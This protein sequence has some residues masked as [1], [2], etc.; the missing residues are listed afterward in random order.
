[1]TQTLLYIFFF[2]VLLLPTQYQNIRGILLLLLCIS[3][4]PKKNYPINKGII[5]C[6]FL[7]VF[8]TL[9]GITYGKIKGNPGA[10]S[11]ITVDLLWPS[12]YIFFMLKC[13]SLD[14]IYKLIKVLIYGG[15]FV[16]IFNLIL[17]TNHFWGIEIIHKLSN[18][19]GY[20]FGFYDGFVE[21]FTPSLDFFSYFLFFSITSLLT[22]SKRL[23]VKNIYLIIMAILSIVMILLSGRRMMWLTTLSLPFILFYIFKR[24]NIGSDL[25]HKMIKVSIIFTFIIGI[26]LIYILDFDSILDQFITS[27]EFYDDPSNL[28]RTLQAQ[29]LWNDFIKSP[30]IGQGIGWASSYVRSE[31]PWEYELSYNYMLASLGLLGSAVRFFSTLWVIEKCLSFVKKTNKYKELLLPPISGLLSMLINYASNPYLSKFDFLWIL[32]FPIIILN[33]LLKTNKNNIDFR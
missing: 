23:G 1:M 14:V 27:F 12:L 9:L 25:L 22:P 7:N 8:I 19:L 3:A 28:E 30:I 11:T 2:F 26:F 29:S 33:I 5:L 24:A 18:D 31:K 4:I 6:F 21:Y 15:I 10:F 20:R 17:L 32:F 13:A 16:L